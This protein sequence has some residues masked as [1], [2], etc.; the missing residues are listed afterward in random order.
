MK[1]KNFCKKHQKP[2]IVQ[3][4]QLI[5]PD[6]LADNYIKRLKANISRNLKKIKN[7]KRER[8]VRDND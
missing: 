7:R 1:K 4:G 6:C 2:K 8:K 3:D 5:C